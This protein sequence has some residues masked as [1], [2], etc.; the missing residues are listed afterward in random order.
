MSPEAL[1]PNPP[2]RVRKPTPMIRPQTTFL[3]TNNQ[4]NFQPKQLLRKSPSLTEVKE[5]D[6]PS[7]QQDF[8]SILK[9]RKSTE[10]VSPPIE[11]PEKPVD[12]LRS[13]LKSP[14]KTPHSPPFPKKQPESSTKWYASP[15]VTPTSPH[16]TLGD[17]IDRDDVDSSDL[18]ENLHAINVD[19]IS[20][21]P[22]SSIKAE[23][24]DSAEIAASIPNS[25]ASNVTASFSNAPASLSDSPTSISDSLNTS[26]SQIDKSTSLSP[27]SACFPDKSASVSDVS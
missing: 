8:R 21:S 10:E 13:I 17:K 4:E 1:K 7:T 15:M 2:A 18:N 14:T 16:Q 20:L 25:P 6:Q 27:S 3:P 26:P 22:D 24:H 12:S 9:T 11:A 19:N 5:N 23:K